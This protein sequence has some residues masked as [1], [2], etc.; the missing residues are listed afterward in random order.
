MMRL[1]GK[2]AV[3]AG[4]SRGIGKGVALA[5]AAEGAHVVL[6]ARRDGSP[7]FPGAMEAAL[8]EIHSHGGAATALS[9]EIADSADVAAMIGA[10]L[11]EFGKIDILVNSAVY[12]NYDSLLEITDEAWG[13]AFDVNV[14]GAFNLTRAVAPS[15]IAHG[16]GH[17]IHLTGAGARDVGAVNSLTG[18]TK[19]ALERF[20]KGA[21]EELRPHKVAVNLFDPGGVKTERAIL[22]RGEDYDWGGFATPADVAPAAVHLALQNVESMTG[23]IFSYQDYIGATS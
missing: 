22:R 17:I 11:G 15:M 4:A 19:A 12:I 20:A 18:A 7:Q 9:C 23:Q 8:A 1:A 16:G 6:V 10:V 21:A 5:F 3:V 13:L 14:K 2:T